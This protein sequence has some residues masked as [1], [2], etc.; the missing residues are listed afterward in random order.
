M[1]AAATATA[2]A[3][4][5]SKAAET[6]GGAIC[7]LLELSWPP[8]NACCQERFCGELAVGGMTN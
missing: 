2:A 4:N 7:S 8:G 1:A 5:M 3:L 6:D